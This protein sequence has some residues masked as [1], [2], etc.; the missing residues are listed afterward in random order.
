LSLCR[1]NGS[2]F[3]V[4]K[5]LEVHKLLLRHAYALTDEAKQILSDG[6]DTLK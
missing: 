4:K 1:I 2:P 5:Y 6:P 3:T